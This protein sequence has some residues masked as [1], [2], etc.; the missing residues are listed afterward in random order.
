M[1]LSTDEDWPNRHLPRAFI[2]RQRET[3]ADCEDVQVQMLCGVKLV[4]AY[5][6]VTCERRLV[7]S[8]TISA[9]YKSHPR[10]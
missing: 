9:Q 1:N 7:L 6:K 4:R 10:V 3:E 5:R 2:I 8:G